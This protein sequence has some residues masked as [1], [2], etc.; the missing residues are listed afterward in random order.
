[1]KIVAAQDIGR[2]INPVTAEGQVEG[3]GIQGIGM[4][5][6]EDFAIN[7]VTGVLESTNFTNYKVCTTLDIPEFEVIL[8]EESTP[9]GPFG[10]K[11]VGESGTIA[12]APAIYNAIYD[13]TGVRIKNM[14]ITPEQIIEG[15][16]AKQAGKV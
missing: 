13:A 9:T 4:A 10:A 7:K 15:L 14:P 11:S 5:L 16:A 8:I 2:A 6:S 1:M 3:G 12:I